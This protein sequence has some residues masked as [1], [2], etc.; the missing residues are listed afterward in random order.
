[1]KFYARNTGRSLK[2]NIDAKPTLRKGNGNDGH[3]PPGHRKTM[4]G[5]QTFIQSDGCKFSPTCDTCPKKDCTV[6]L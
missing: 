5:K 1:M 2:L 3:S 6:N 4:N